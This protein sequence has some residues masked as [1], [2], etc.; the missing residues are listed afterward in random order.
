MP[1][2][3]P[4]RDATSSRTGFATHTRTHRTTVTSAAERVARVRRSLGDAFIAAVVTV[5]QVV[6]SAG[7]VAIGA[8]IIGGAL[9][10]RFGWTEW[11]VAALISATM[12]VCAIAF[13]SVRRRYQVDLAMLRERVVAGEVATGDVVVTNISKRLALPGTVEV[14]MGDAVA[15]V[16]VPMLR[17]GQ[18]YAH[19]IELPTTHRGVLAVGPVR[20]VRADP[21]GLL[22]VQTQWARSYDLFVHPRTTT[23]PTTNAGLIRDLEGNAT[24]TVTASDISFHALREYAPG[25]SRRHIH[26]KSTAK[27][28]ALMV[29]QFEETRRAKMSLMISGAAQDYADAEEYELAVSALASL[30]VRGLRDGRELDVVTPAITPDYAREPVVEIVQLPTVTPR[31][32][33]DALSGIDAQVTSASL[34]QVTDLVAQRTPGLS[35]AVFFCGSVVPLRELQSAALRLPINAG[36]LVVIADPQA[37]PSVR[38]IS[39][40]TIV[41]IALLDDLRHL[42]I[43]GVSE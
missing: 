32:L 20:A 36:A 15:V 3:Y 42:L 40:L 28:G 41:T 33:L 43:K 13:V 29:R 22:R 21:I 11:A 34:A 19:S 16:D 2:E 4:T 39:G 38:Q 25:D 37:S 31:T 7:W 9:A 23:V 26:W 12:L 6:T 1:T 30:A 27:T 14:P 17:G 10:W 35:I 24:S 8:T 18:E 5:W